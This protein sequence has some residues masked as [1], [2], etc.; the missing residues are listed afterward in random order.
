MSENAKLLTKG[1][2][3]S[4]E[5]GNRIGRVQALP[6]AGIAGGIAI[7]APEDSE[8][9]TVYYATPNLN[10]V[11]S[12]SIPHALHDFRDHDV[13][14]FHPF[15]GA[16]DV[17]TVRGV[18]ACAHAQVDGKGLLYMVTDGGRFRRV[19]LGAGEPDQPG[20]V[21]VVNAIDHFDVP[22]GGPVG[23]RTRGRLRF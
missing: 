15:L 21:A 1:M 8:F 6:L 11:G 16:E 5:R 17:N 7:E 3:N 18:A 2:R 4:I 12:V 14:G 20:K 23:R 9:L 13:A 19:G 10:S 22:T